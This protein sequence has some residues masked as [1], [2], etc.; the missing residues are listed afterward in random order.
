M[1]F[2]IILTIALTLLLQAC[3]RKQDSMYIDRFELVNRHNILVEE[4]DT[5]AS[6]SA[7]NGN[8]AFTTDFTGLQTFFREYENGVSLGTLSNWGWHTISNKE[9]YDISGTYYYYEIDG[10]TVPF[11]DQRISDR[12]SSRAVEAVN[13][14]RG[15]PHRLHLGIIRLKI[16]KEN[17]EEIGICD[18]QQPKHKLDLWRGEVS[19]H[20][21]I[22][23]QPV[24][25]TV[26]VHQEIDMVAARIESPLIDSGRLAVEWLFP[27]GKVEHTH[28]GY[29]FDS[30]DRHTSTILS[31]TEDRA[32]ISRQLDDDSYYVS[33]GWSNGAEL[34]EKSRH[35]FLLK[36]GS[37]DGILEFSCLYSPTLITDDLPG[38]ERT[39]K[40]NEVYWENFWESGGAVDFSACTDPR[41]FELERRTVLSQYLTRINGSGNLPPQETGLTFNSWFGK[42]H[43]EMIWWHSAHYH[44]W[45]RSE[46]MSGQLGYYSDIFD[47]ARKT[48]ELQG[49]AGVRWPKMVGPDGSDSPSSVGTYLIWQQPHFIYFAKQLYRE[50]PSRE[51]L[52]QYADLVFATADFMAGFPLY[53]HNNDLYNLAPPL[54][55]AQ[56]HWNRE[57]TFNPPFELAYWYWGLTVAQ[58]WRIRLGKEPDPKWEEVRTKLPAPVAAG[59]L[60]LGIANAPDSYTDPRNMRDHPMVLGALGMLPE[61]EKLDKEI[62]RNTLKLIMEKWNWASTWGW[63]YPMVAMCAARLLEP[64]IAL[65]ALLKDVQKNTYLV[66]GHNYQDQ[67]L[68]IYLPGN[69]GLLK[70]IAL[71]C[72][73]WEG[74]ETENPGFPKDGSWNVRWENLTPDF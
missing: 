6:L 3:N 16:I 32:V 56:E 54:I 72:A 31:N 38:F 49:Y 39:E 35:R 52:E 33:I 17:G 2:K 65:E 26:F 36:P 73:G 61:W 66:N 10:R 14:F 21:Y 18:V 46:Y 45:Q 71:M 12:S 11:R 53:D 74:C 44:N 43:L 63:D 58:K 48:A 29:D 30:P 24:D 9:N 4:F 20:F 28:P 47:Q 34:A 40:E 23:G 25:V 55:P 7:G 15:N 50:N 57:T 41:A 19:S 59:G 62:M 13:Y 42:F 70:A 5:L 64:E 22:E 51:V 60:Y 8:F 68:R 69:G 1:T 27:Y 37:D 67:R